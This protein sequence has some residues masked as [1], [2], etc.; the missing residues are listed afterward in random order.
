[1]TQADATIEREIQAARDKLRQDLV[2][3]AADRAQDI[4]AK[5]ITDSDQ[6]HLVKEFIERVEKLH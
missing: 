4:V 5:N 3:I 1:L 2:D 6:E